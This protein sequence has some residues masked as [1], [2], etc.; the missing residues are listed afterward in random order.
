[1]LHSYLYYKTLFLFNSFSSDFQI[2]SRLQPQITLYW[3][4]LD[5]LHSFNTLL[6]TYSLPL[7]MYETLQCQISAIKSICWNLSRYGTVLIIYIVCTLGVFK[8]MME[9][10]ISQLQVFIGLYKLRLMQKLKKSWN[11]YLGILRTTFSRG[12]CKKN[13]MSK[14][15]SR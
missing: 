5:N 7:Y 1:M 13:I 15:I 8:V 10:I 9:G 12:V 11:R 4:I 14:K 2:C 6:L 3:F